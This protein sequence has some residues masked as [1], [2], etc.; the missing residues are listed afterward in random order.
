[1]KR[2]ALPFT[3]VVTFTI[4]VG[5][6]HLK[7]RVQGLER[8]LSQ[9]NRTIVAHRETIRVLHSEW[10]FLNQPGTVEDLAKRL[11]DMRPNTTAQVIRIEDLPMRAVAAD[12]GTT[13]PIGTP[14]KLVERTGARK[15][16]AQ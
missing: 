14:A 4:V 1:M 13:G 12:T 9:V 11:L 8:E 5:L 6:F 2:F 16:S 7:Q 3:L 10:S 15:E